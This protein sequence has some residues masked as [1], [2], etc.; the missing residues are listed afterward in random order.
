MVVPNGL[1]SSFL[2]GAGVSGVGIVDDGV[3]D[4]EE[5][6]ILKEFEP[7]REPLRKE[8]RFYRAQLAAEPRLSPGSNEGIKSIVGVINKILKI[9]RLVDQFK[10]FSNRRIT[11][12]WKLMNA[13]S[14]GSSGISIYVPALV[15]FDEWVKADCSSVQLVGDTE[16]LPLLQQ[17]RLMS[18]ISV[19]TNGS[20]LPFVAYCPRKD[21][22]ENGRSLSIVKDAIKNH[23]FVGVKLYPPMG[24]YPIG[25]GDLLDNQICNSPDDSEYIDDLGKNID[26]RLNELYYWCEKSNVPIMAHGNDS[27]GIVDEF[28][29]RSEPEQWRAVLLKYPALRINLGHF[30]GMDGF[31][32]RPGEQWAVSILNLMAE[33]ENLYADTG[34][35]DGVIRNWL[36]ELAGLLDGKFFPRFFAKRNYFNQLRSN[37]IRVNESMFDEKYRVTDR[38]LYGSDWH[39]LASEPYFQNYYRDFKKTYKSYLSD[40]PHTLG[41]SDDN[42]IG[43]NAVRFLGLDLVDDR[44]NKETNMHYLKQFYAD[45]AVKPSWTKYLPE[46][47]VLRD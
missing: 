28:D 7:N 40:M 10:I 12:T 44:K 13:Y 4:I 31:L 18:K 45:N 11:N 39:M 42:F 2:D 41:D 17:V 34:N 29:S 23:G 38:L 25:N 47:C 24:F 14:V 27:L 26:T 3:S 43:L 30:G 16:K 1:S 5:I 19:V 32:G 35:F 36:S 8:I 46:H 6:L 9:M 33:H 22:I 20:V 15:D 37:M 21:V